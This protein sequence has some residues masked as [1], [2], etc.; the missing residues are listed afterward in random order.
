MNNF[1]RSLLLVCLLPTLPAVAQGGDGLVGQL[2]TAKIAYLTRQ[3]GLTPE[4]A[5]RFWPVYNEFTAKRRDLNRRMPQLLS[6][7]DLSEAQIKANLSQA[8]ILR[9][10]EVDLEKEY[11]DKFQKLIT[12]R[13]VGKLFVAER[14]FTKEVLRRVAARRGG[15]TA[16]E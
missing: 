10:Q 6:T 15:S 2:E 4:Q 9:H 1:L 3:V 7:N 16:E 5:Q 12:I 11:F 14:E 13:Q 8:L